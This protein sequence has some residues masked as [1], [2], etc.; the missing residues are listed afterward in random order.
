MD[1]ITKKAYKPVSSLRA[2]IC[3]V[4]V[5]DYAAINGIEY[6]LD[7]NRG[8]FTLHYNASIIPMNDEIR[9]A[10]RFPIWNLAQELL[11]RSYFSTLIGS[12]Y[13]LIVPLS[14]IL[15]SV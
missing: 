14:G 12:F 2:P 11:T 10:F 5:L 15:L 1:Y 4:V 7:Y 13:I 3:D 8:L 9:N 6:V